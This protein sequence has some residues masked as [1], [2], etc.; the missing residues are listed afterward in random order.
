MLPQRLGAVF[1]VH[2]VNLEEIAEAAGKGNRSIIIRRRYP[3]HG[4]VDV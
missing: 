4:K 2:K 1:N 3:P